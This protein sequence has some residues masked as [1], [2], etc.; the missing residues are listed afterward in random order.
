MNDFE[1]EQKW[2]EIRHKYPCQ[3]VLVRNKGNGYLLATEYR[4]VDNKTYLTFDMLVGCSTWVFVGAEYLKNIKS[5]EV[6]WK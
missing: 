2:K 1:F 3:Y 5:L 4:W 6:G